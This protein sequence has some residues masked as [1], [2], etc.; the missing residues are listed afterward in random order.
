MNTFVCSNKFNKKKIIIAILLLLFAILST[1]NIEKFVCADNSYSDSDIETQ[2]SNSVN[3]IVSNIDLSQMEGILDEINE[4][5]IINSSIGDKLNDILNGKYFTDYKSIISG[6]FGL[7]FTDIRSILPMLFTIIAIGILASMFINFGSEKQGVSDIVSFVFLGVIAVVVLVV[8][9]NVFGITNKSFGL[10]SKQMQI[11]F[12]ILIT[13]LTSIGS[14]SSISIYN[15]LV[16][17]LTTIITY[18]FEKFLYPIFI[19]I[20][21]LTIMKCLTKTINLDK[22]SNFFNSLF[23]WSIGLIFTIFTGFL[24][25]Q[26][27]SAGKFDSISIKTTKFAMK[28]Y[29]PII[30]SYISDGMDFLIL[31]SVLVKNAI[32]LIGVII[33]FLTII[34]PIINILIYKFALQLA[35]SVVDLSGNSKIADFLTNCSKILIMP[36]VLILGASLMYVIT[37]TLIMCTANIF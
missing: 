37:I 18:V 26:G 28:S 22:L 21:I 34:T 33:I 29:I 15:P 1:M 35:G 6:I 36:I 9:K 19:V 32:G 30:G 25:I 2:L 8:F 31:G 5:G 10:I 20:F 27:I 7:I 12:P 4:F 14:F 16:A 11:I 23:K 3:D 17:V 13:L 24:T